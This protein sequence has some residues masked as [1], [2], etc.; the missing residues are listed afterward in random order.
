MGN[1]VVSMPEI[2][3][4]SI[5]AGHVYVKHLGHTGDKVRRLADPRT[6]PTAIAGRWWPP[7][8]L[9]ARWVERHREEFDIADVHFGFDAVDP[10]DL[11]AFVDALH[12]QGKPLVYTAD[13][14]R[15][16]HHAIPHAHQAHL[17]VLIPRADA[18]I[19]LTEGAADAIDRTWGRRP[20]VIAHPHVVDDH[21]M[22]RPRGPRSEEYVVGVHCKSVR[23]SMAPGPV[24]AALL[25]L[26]EELPKLRLVVDVHDDVADP[27]GARHDPQ[28]MGLLRDADRA[29]LLH[30]SV[31]DCYS[32]EELWD[33]L[34]CLD[35]SVLPYRF[36]THSGWLEAC[37]DLGTIVLAP[38]CGF[39]AQQRRCLTYRM[40]ETGLDRDSL[41]DAV[42]A[43]Y[44]ERPVWR[45]L[46]EARASERAA[47]AAAHR[48]VYEAVLS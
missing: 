36:G 20:L 2:L 33:Y 27:R 40:D 13:D 5:P 11:S 7:V 23:A 1:A 26:V 12:A 43:A 6:G 47:I 10:G 35:L 14:L 34:Q 29:G 8:M 28:L 32:D 17:D 25:P 3:V 16:P 41:Q 30:L 46:P 4:A 48:A 15:N 38:T 45:A 37:Y 44:Q 9:D 31:H 18:L 19:T 21:R 39:F 42:R 22:R 24:L